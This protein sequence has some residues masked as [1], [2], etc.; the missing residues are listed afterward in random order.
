MMDNLPGGVTDSMVDDA[1]GG[2]WLDGH[3]DGCNGD[4]CDCLERA[5]AEAATE[6]RW[7]DY[8]YDRGY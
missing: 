8:C 7:D 4:F 2:D 5:A 1:V 6:R 3:D